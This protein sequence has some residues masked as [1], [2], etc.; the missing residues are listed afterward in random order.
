VL[1]DASGHGVSSAFMMSHTRICLRALARCYAEVGQIFDC[2]NRALMGELPDDA[3]GTH[4]L[5]RL[6]EASRRMTYVGAGQPPAYVMDITGK[7]EV[8][9][10]SCEVPLG[11]S[12]D[13]LYVSSDPIRL[14]PGESVLFTT[15]GILRALAS[16]GK[17]F[18]AQRLLE[19][20]HAN[21]RRPAAEIL[22]IV[23]NV[24]TIANRNIPLD[25]DLTAVLILAK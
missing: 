13:A 6:D 2:A 16:D 12:E 8:V 7:V 24:V 1:G 3:F 23:Q 25:D 17:P 4:A 22:E 11:I 20:V 21:R 10:K 19:I 14:A 18:G 9:L 15:R 5:I